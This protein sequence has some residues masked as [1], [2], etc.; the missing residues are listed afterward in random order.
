MI[1]GGMG[2][3]KRGGVHGQQAVLALLLLG[4]PGALAQPAT[5]TASDLDLGLPL[6]P[7]VP[8]L[9]P[10]QTVFTWEP[11][12]GYKDNVALSAVRPSGS[13][14]VRNLAEVIFWRV[15]ANGW[16]MHAYLSGEDI[17]YLSSPVVDKEQTALG[18]LQVNR[19]LS[20]EWS[21]GLTGQYLYQNRVLDL[22]TSLATPTVLTVEGHGYS[23][24]GAFRRKLGD[25]WTWGLEPTVTRQDFGGPLDDYWEGGA[26]LSLSRA[27][28]WKSEATVS[29]ELNQ[30][31]HDRREQASLAGFS[32]PGS[33]LGF[34]QHRVQLQWKHHWDEPRRWRTTAKISHEWSHDNGSGYFDSRRW[35]AGAEARFANSQWEIRL[36]SRVSGTVFPHQPVSPTEPRAA[37]RTDVTLNLR[38]EKPIT[39]SLRWFADWDLERSMSNRPATGYAVNLTQSGLMLE[40]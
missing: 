16:E 27:Y 24:R 26:K 18:V 29:H 14:M 19:T 5:P 35:Q 36:T 8:M 4:V 7:D 34:R 17:R 31:L 20:A 23:A 40:F 22:T 30:R 21:A 33:E 38:V 2:I 37:R 1:L 12:A 39:Q 10:W 6:L 15:P 13:A 3:L 25:E 28:G 9:R 32:V 11:S